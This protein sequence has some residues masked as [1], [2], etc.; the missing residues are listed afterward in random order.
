MNPELRTVCA[1]WFPE[2]CTDT[3]EPP[4]PGERVSHGACR[5]C[6]DAYLRDAGI[7]PEEMTR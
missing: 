5:A 3:S 2:V 6:A 7:E 1:K 4:R